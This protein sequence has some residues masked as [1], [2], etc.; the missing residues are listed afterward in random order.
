MKKPGETLRANFGQEAFAFDIDKMVQVC[1]IR[2]FSI[3]MGLL[4]FQEEKAQIQAEIAAKKA[5]RKYEHDKPTVDE[6]QF[7]HRLVSQYL[8]HDGYVETAR[9]FA[10]E[11]NEE[12]RALANDD[13]A[14]IAYI[15]AEEDIDAVNRQSTFRPSQFPP[16]SP[17]LLFS[18]RVLTKIYSRNPRSN[19]RR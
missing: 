17:I 14:T 2:I 4:F 10:K 12:E 7:I 11:V 6:T 16:L 18:A 5:S 19:S 3:D 13:D 15:E 9:A 8:A 1:R